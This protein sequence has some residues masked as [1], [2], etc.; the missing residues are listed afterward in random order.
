MERVGEAAMRFME[1]SFIPLLTMVFAIGISQVVAE[2]SPPSRWKCSLCGEVK[3]QAVQ[4]QPSTNG[5]KAAQ[6]KKHIWFQIQ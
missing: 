5:C 3:R 6:D 4:S 1:K 2:S